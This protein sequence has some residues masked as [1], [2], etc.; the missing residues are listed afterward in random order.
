MYHSVGTPKSGDSYGLTVSKE[1]FLD[2]ISHL[3]NLNTSFTAVD[4]RLSSLVSL[5]L[6][7]FGISFDDGYKDNLIA[8]EILISHSIPFSIYCIADKIGTDDYLSM[9]DLRDL[10]ATGLCTVGGHGLTHR[11]LGD[12]N[13]ADQINELRRCRDIL[14]QG[15]GLHVE[16]MS[17]PHG[18]HNSKTR[19]L[20]KD[21]GYKLICTSRPGLNTLG[22]F[23]PLH[24]RRTE[25]RAHDSL[26]SFKK[27]SAGSDDWRDLVYTGRSL[28]SW[29]TDAQWKRFH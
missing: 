3:V 24:V 20:A 8:S 17:L 11:R 18:S 28:L 25:I 16:T 26:D 4:S 27:K 15:L 14:E 23:D 22:N 5:P 10:S 12:L 6:S 7:S 1:S 13:V 21:S 19:D 9:Q 29:A 2:Q